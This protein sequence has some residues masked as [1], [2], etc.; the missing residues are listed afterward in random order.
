MEEDAFDE[1]IT[2]G[3]AKFLKMTTEPVERLIIKMAIPT[4]LIMLVSAMYNTAD[5][6]FVGS[7][8]TA[9]TGAIGVNLALMNIVQATGFFFG[10][11]AGNFISRALG[12]KDRKAAE[13]MASTGFFLAFAFGCVIAVLGSVFTEPLAR[14]LGST[15]TILPYAMD[16]LR[17]IL[18]AAP[19]MVSSIVLN[20]L[21]R[22]QGSAMFSAVGMISGA[23]LN[24]GLDPLFIFVFGW[25]VKGAAIATGISQLVGF[26]LLLAGCR[27]GGNVRI[28]LK[29]FAL[30]PDRLLN[31]VRGG[32]PSLLR[33]SM[34]SLA[35][36]FLNNSAKVYGDAVIA[37][38]SV[39]NRTVMLSGSVMLGL[40]QGFQP[41]CGFNFGARL[42][43]RV[44]RG[45]RFCVTSSAILLAFVGAACFI[46]APEIIAFFRNDPKVISVGT[47]ALRA[48]ACIMPLSSWI[49]LCN[50]TLQTTG[51]AVPASILSFARQGFFQ[52][53]FILLLV[54]VFG[55]LGIQLS[56]PISDFCMFLL[57][58]PFGISAL[59]RMKED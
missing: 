46:F 30:K 18:L 12:A 9:A 48:Q 58:L 21:L 38:I 15:D 42:Y 26:F 8:S 28:S 10:Q 27:R 11:G 56:T 39:V 19:F 36:I 45:F 51:Q 20:N 17:Y 49:V 40:G 24:C 35:T 4:V 5:T 6:Y 47:L 31:L 54:P 44:K 37:A 16:Y 34:M 2:E 7:L 59:R 55:V 53:P 23:V 57:S 50:T 41:V 25:G 13:E 14:A 22:F 32:T 52:I 29:H 33:Q 43:N 1:E 3:D